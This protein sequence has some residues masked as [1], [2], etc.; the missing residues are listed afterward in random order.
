[1]I[2][3]MN[4]L[5]LKI[6]LITVMTFFITHHLLAADK[7][8]EVVDDVADQVKTSNSKKESTG[9]D[10]LDK[11]LEIPKVQTQYNNCKKAGIS[12]EK[13]PDCIWNGDN[14]S[15]SALDDETKKQVTTSYQKEKTAKGS[16]EADL[17]IKSNTLSTN[18]NNNSTFKKLEEIV[19]QQLKEELFGKDA[20]DSNGKIKDRTKVSSLDHKV[21]N[22]L[23]KSELSK[24]V[25]D[26]FTSYCLKVNYD[27]PYANKTCEQ[28]KDDKIKTCM[29]SGKTKD[30]CDNYSCQVYLQKGVPQNTL[31]LPECS[32][33]SKD[34]EAKDKCRQAVNLKNLESADFN[35]DNNKQWTACIVS[36]PQVCYDEISGTD[37]TSLEGT[38]DS[39]TTVTTSNQNPKKLASVS[40]KAST[41]A[42]NSTAEEC[43]SRKN[44]CLIA[45]YARAIKKNLMLTKKIETE[46]YDKYL[47]TAGSMNIINSAKQENIDTIK[48]VTVSSKDIDDAYKDEAKKVSKTAEDC[49]NNNTE[50]CST[51]LSTNTNENEKSVVEYGLRQFA[52]EESLNNTLTDEQSLKK[53]MKAQGMSDEQ[54]ASKFSEMKNDMNAIKSEI[55]KK[56]AVEKENLIKELSEKVKGKSTTADGKVDTQQ[57]ISKINNIKN[58]YATKNDEYK[59]IVKFA[60]IAESYLEV[61]KSG[62]ENSRNTASLFSEISDT[63]KNDASVQAMKQ[64]AQGA[65]LKDTKENT[66]IGIDV[67]N[68]I[69]LLGI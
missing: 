25:I 32:D 21:F 57:D 23:Y 26:A 8:Q 11:L 14:N 7:A 38:Q 41:C 34:N 12:T 33:T 35:K 51:I 50:K 13:M 39:T 42:S 64:R 62:G 45:D 56:F 37:G 16:T 46:V 61:Q 27:S 19:D 31:N 9:N 15:I 68:I 24:T 30:K 60:N 54:I 49:A 20:L 43:I 66:V 17:S 47:K 53:Y 5:L 63:E 40:T 4:K 69:D 6:S 29:A 55:V 44:A 10:T 28:T 58:E 52:Q 18:Y 67:E 48:A 36:V 1:M 2:K 65:G 22:D 59:N 3:A